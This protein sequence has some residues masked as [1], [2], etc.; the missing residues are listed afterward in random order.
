MSLDMI[1]VQGTNTLDLEKGPGHY[2]ET[3]DPWDAH[4]PS[5]IGA[6]VQS[7]TVC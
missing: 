6:K 1:V 7:P 2:T 3:A 4:Y 5:P